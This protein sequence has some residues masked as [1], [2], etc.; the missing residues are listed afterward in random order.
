MRL[1]IGTERIE[2]HLLHRRKSCDNTILITGLRHIQIPAVLIEECFR[3]RIAE[4]IAV[5]GKKL[6]DRPLAEI[7]RIG[8]RIN[9]LCRD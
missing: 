5:T 4:I 9:L 2:I 1:L 6:A 7:L 3:I 8:I